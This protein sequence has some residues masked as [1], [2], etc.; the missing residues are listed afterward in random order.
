MADKRHPIPSHYIGRRGFR[1]PFREGGGRG[2]K[3]PGWAICLGVDRPGPWWTGSLIEKPAFTRVN[4]SNVK[5][6][7]TIIRV[8]VKELL[9][10]T[11]MGQIPV[12]EC[13]LSSARGRLWL[14]P[15]MPGITSLLLPEDPAPGALIR[16]WRTPRRGCR[17]TECMLRR[18]LRIRQTGLTGGE[19]LFAHG[20]R[21]G[22]KD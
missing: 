21:D 11:V 4:L 22:G 20:Y 18:G 14:R 7:M 9:C 10:Q 1:L 19:I 12:L 17:G 8:L 5:V 2:A 6:I 16:Y 15:F 3:P 13:L